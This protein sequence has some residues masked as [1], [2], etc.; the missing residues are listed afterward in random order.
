[1]ESL[2]SGNS[3]PTQL[4]PPANVDD[5]EPHYGLLSTIADNDMIDMENNT[6]TEDMASNESSQNSQSQT[7]TL[8][9]EE[10]PNAPSPVDD[11]ET[12]NGL[13]KDASSDM[14]ATETS[15]FSGND[16]ETNPGH[17]LSIT[18]NA[19]FN[20]NFSI[21]PLSAES[22]ALQ[23][24]ELA[25]SPRPEMTMNSGSKETKISIAAKSVNP[26]PINI[27][28]REKLEYAKVVSQLREVG[29]ALPCSCEP[30]SPTKAIKMPLSEAITYRT[31]VEKLLPYGQVE[32]IS[33]DPRQHL[34]AVVFE[35][36]CQ[37]QKAS[38]SSMKT[39]GPLTPPQNFTSQY[40]PRKYKKHQ[41]NI[42]SASPILPSSPPA[43]PQ[44]FRII[45]RGS[46]SIVDLIADLSQEIGEIPP[47]NI[48]RIKDN[49]NI[50]IEKDAQSLMLTLMD[51]SKSDVIQKVYPH[52]E[53]NNSKAVCHSREL[54]LTK[55]ETIK[56]HSN[57]K[58]K[59]IHQIKGSYSTSIITFPTPQPPDQI[60]I[61]GM[62]FDLEKF[63]EKPRQCNKCFS[64][65]HIPAECGKQPRCNKCSDLKSNHPE[66]TCSKS[67]FCY[68]C[69]GDHPP[70]SRKCQ[71]YLYEEELLNEAINRG[72]GRGHIRAERRRANNSQK[73]PNQRN[74]SNRNIPPNNETER[75]NTDQPQSNTWILKRNKPRRRSR[76]KVN[77][78]TPQTPHDITFETPE[79]Y[80]TKGQEKS[81][82]STE[83]HDHEEDTAT[84]LPGSDEGGKSTE[85]NTT[86]I[87]TEAVT[88]A[89]D[90]PLN[91]SCPIDSTNKVS[92][93]ETVEKSAVP[94][95]PL[96]SGE[97]VDG[98]VDSFREAPIQAPESRKEILSPTTHKTPS[99]K[100]KLTSLPSNELP[101][102]NCSWSQ[103]AVSSQSV[104]TP[105]GTTTNRKI[106]QSRPLSISPPSTKSQEPP[107]KKGKPGSPS[108][109]NTTTT[110]PKSLSSK[111]HKRCSLCGTTYKTPKCLKEHL[112]YFHP[113]KGDIPQ[114]EAVPNR[115]SVKI[116]KEHTCGE[117]TYEQCRTLYEIRKNS[118][119]RGRGSLVDSNG[120]IYA[121]ISDFR[122][123]KPNG[124]LK[125]TNQE[126]IYGPC[127]SEKQSTGNENGNRKRESQKQEI[128]ICKNTAYFMKP[129]S[130][131]NDPEPSPTLS[132]SWQSKANT[133]V[134]QGGS[135]VKGA[136]ARIEGA[137]MEEMDDSPLDHTWPQKEGPLTPKTQYKP[138]RDPRLRSGSLNDLDSLRS[139]VPNIET[140]TLYDDKQKIR[141]NLSPK[142][143][144]RTGSTDSLTA[145]ESY[146]IHTLISIRK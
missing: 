74:E 122:R 144:A 28:N 22:K 126:K 49:F 40:N 117:L 39:I 87:S 121:S 109:P 91:Q 105:R 8:L 130:K 137:I 18:P 41:T 29:T 64:Y 11:L 46:P 69:E 15:N 125:K 42:T 23:Q 140:Q 57:P 88:L 55:I 141:E 131:S 81:S 104:N 50:K 19:G 1:M 7:K 16:P 77:P 114:I 24:T 45:P 9:H 47:K 25:K 33:L 44:F 58:V 90:S 2:P 61:Y 95:K 76:N 129:S 96:L 84:C 3:T 143:L 94:P 12:V 79:A 66:Q 146:P 73:E 134:S 21:E 110:T 136:I 124:H 20:E 115:E 89:D 80:Q 83:H 92:N 118:N 31:V 30:I 132:Q 17:S 56:S 120:A 27:Q 113:K 37:A 101:E 97:S 135:F 78:N 145:K 70:T 14:N 65:M 38:K 68:M 5:P 59:E 63:I 43:L 128:P 112:T 51:F 72:C 139:T 102:T 75:E 4:T 127:I 98:D 123:R 82:K 86:K 36:G 93:R 107:H 13:S 10:M 62:T 142:P 53:L 100:P 103:E 85:P 32:A 106:T 133:K 54:Y 48:T 71:V 67:P 111:K 35:C 138:Q 60:K 119:D 6:A 116:T 52:P 34:H 108:L 26:R 99:V